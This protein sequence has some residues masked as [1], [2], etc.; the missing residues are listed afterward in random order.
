M[1]QNVNPDPS[2]KANKNPKLILK[3]RHKNI[4]Y[5]NYISIFSQHTYCGR[6]KKGNT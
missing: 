6:V 2:G 4:S 1:F 5:M 3:K